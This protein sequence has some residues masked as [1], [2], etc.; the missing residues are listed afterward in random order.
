MPYNDYSTRYQ[1]A[2]QEDRCAPR[3]P[4]TIPGKLRASGDRAIPVEVT[5]LSLAGFACE[6]LT[7]MPPGTVCWLTLPGLGSLQAEIAWNNRVMIGCSFVNMLSQPV[8]DSLLARYS[9]NVSAY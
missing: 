5:D 4:I 1:T 2:A 3:M 7:R 8:L 6:A 9:Q